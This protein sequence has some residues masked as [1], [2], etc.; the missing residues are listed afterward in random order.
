MD[1]LTFELSGAEHILARRGETSV[2]MIRTQNYL[3]AGLSSMRFLAGE[4]CSSG[5]KASFQLNGSVYLVA[6]I[7]RVSGDAR[8]R[9][10]QVDASGLSATVPK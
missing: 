6:E 3:P 10:A 8:S 2:A 9:S 5:V 7:Q 4:L 1:G